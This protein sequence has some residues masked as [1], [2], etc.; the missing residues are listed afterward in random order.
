MQKI[1]QLLHDVDPYVGLK[2]VNYKP[3][4]QG[5]DST[6][7]IFA[8]LIRELKPQLILEVGTWK[9]ASALHMAQLL[10]QS[11]LLDAEICC[12]DTWLGALEF[13][14]WSHDDADRY[15]S[16]KMVHGFPTVYYTFLRNVA[17]HGATNFITPF[18][19]TSAIAARFFEHHKIL[20]D[21]IY[22]DGSHDY[23]DVSAD[24]RAYWRLTRP[25]GVLFGDDYANITWE[26]VTR[27][28]DEFAA[29]LGAPPAIAGHKWVM[30]KPIEQLQ[31]SGEADTG[32]AA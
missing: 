13:W 11:G 1:R 27:A 5:W 23:P 6:H 25:G 20:F 26:G 28:V 7:P 18:P 10:L 19:T 24:I 31:S 8:N 3:D 22:I 2:I 4:L 30:R 16:L 32:V 21:L 15:Q 17:A 14:L 12:V 9:G 29:E